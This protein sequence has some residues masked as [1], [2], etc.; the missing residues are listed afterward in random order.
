MQPFFYTDDELV[1]LR[2]RA[3]T[4]A[5]YDTTSHDEAKVHDAP[6]PG[7][8]LTTRD[9]DGYTYFS[10]NAYS[11]IKKLFNAGPAPCVVR[12][13]ARWRPSTPRG[14]PI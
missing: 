11:P 6:C 1:G 5:T 3:R 10:T 9:E 12:D 13:G 2:H 14:P 4:I 7:L 8:T